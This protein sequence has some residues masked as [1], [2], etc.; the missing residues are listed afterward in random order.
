MNQLRLVVAGK[1]PD[2]EFCT[3]SDGRRVEVLMPG[4]DPQKRWIPISP[5]TGVTPADW[6][7]RNNRFDDV[8][9]VTNPMEGQW[10]F[11][12]QYF[13]ITCIPRQ[14][15]G[16]AAQ[17]TVEQTADAQPEALAPDAAAGRRRQP[18]N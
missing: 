7:I 18:G 9:V 4:M 1:Q 13:P 5:R 6:E 11:R 8:L 16:E 15:E 10:G 3:V 17:T 12:V 14:G 2:D